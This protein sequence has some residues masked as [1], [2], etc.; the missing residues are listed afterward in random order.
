[1]IKITKENFKEEVVDCK[2]PVLIDFWASW[3]GP[4][5]MLSPII[6]EIDSEVSGVKV[7]KVNVDEE[8]ALARQFGIMSIP[9][10]VVVKDGTVVDTS[11]GVVSKE[12]ILS[13]LGK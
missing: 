4:C 10:L 1:M 6:G 13:M 3:C 12:K 8:Q 11:V 9:T 2:E 5:N 7:G